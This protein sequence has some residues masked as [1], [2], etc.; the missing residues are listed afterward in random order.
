MAGRRL[1][2][3]VCDR[4]EEQAVAALRKR[5]PLSPSKRT[6]RQASPFGGVG[7]RWKKSRFRTGFRVRLPDGSR[8]WSGSACLHFCQAFREPC[9]RCQTS[10][11]RPVCV[12]ASARRWPLPGNWGRVGGLQAAERRT[13][14][15]ICTGHP[16]VAPQPSQPEAANHPE[17]LRESRMGGHRWE[18]IREFRVGRTRA[19]IATLLV[20]AAIACT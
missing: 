9:A 5:V 15:R 6:S 20:A 3:A 14:L 19:F 11:A 10:L 8:R 7:E 12:P 4:I 13:W 2:T 16:P 1:E 17:A 18:V